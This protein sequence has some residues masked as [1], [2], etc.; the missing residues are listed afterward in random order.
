MTS[1][2]ATEN[3]ESREGVAPSTNDIYFDPTTRFIAIKTGVDAVLQACEHA[4]KAVR[5][6]MIYNTTLG[7]DYF[8]T[9]FNSDPNV[10]AFETSA[11]AQ[12]LRVPD[13]IR[14]INFLADL[15]AAKNQLSY[16]AEIE[17]IYGMGVISG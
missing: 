5:G 15:D 6:E 10:L 8:G 4:V 14:V 17:T 9:V 16:Y 11:E 7:T 13:V 1:I 2:L 3:R 12:I